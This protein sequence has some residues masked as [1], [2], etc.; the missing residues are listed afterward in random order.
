MNRLLE[1]DYNIK[2]TG[3]H[4]IMCNMLI[5]KY[6]LCL[7]SFMSSKCIDNLQRNKKIFIK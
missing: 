1:S 2:S 3:Q 4:Y 6:F 5:N 7:F